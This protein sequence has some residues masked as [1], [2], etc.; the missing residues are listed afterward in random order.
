MPVVVLVMRGSVLEALG[1]TRS[2]QN[3]NLPTFW[4]TSTDALGRRSQTIRSVRAIAVRRTRQL[5]SR[6]STP[7]G[8]QVT[9]PLVLLTQA[10]LPESKPALTH[11]MEPGPGCSTKREPTCY[12]RR[13]VAAAF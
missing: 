3:L 2:M 12:P 9:Q 10:V 6:R 11:H 1:T 13:R 8:L 5:P 7:L 4:R